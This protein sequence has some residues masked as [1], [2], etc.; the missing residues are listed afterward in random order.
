MA[1]LNIRDAALTVGNGELTIRGR[2]DIAAGNFDLKLDSS[3]DPNLFLP[4]LPPG[5]T[6][7]VRDL[8]VFEPPKISVR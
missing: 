4:S 5:I 2:Y 1:R 8:H 6:A 3:L 7:V